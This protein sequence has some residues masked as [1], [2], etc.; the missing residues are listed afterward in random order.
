MRM[1]FYSF[2]PGESSGTKLIYW[3]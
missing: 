2:G 3:K 1:G